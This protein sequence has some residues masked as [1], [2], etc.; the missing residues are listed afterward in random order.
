VTAF[1]E[2]AGAIEINTQNAETGWW[3]GRYDKVQK[4]YADTE[5]GY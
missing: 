2:K 1:L 5:K 3:I 4:L